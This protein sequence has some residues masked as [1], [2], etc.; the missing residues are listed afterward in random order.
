MMCCCLLQD[1]NP[2]SFSTSERATILS[3][4][5]TVS[6]DFAPFNV[7]VTTEDPALTNTPLED[8]LRVAIG[9]SS[10]DCEQGLAGVESR[11]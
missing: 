11:V 4:W 7:D 5:R 6:E 10:G 9:G 8:W 2:S 3:V 1:G